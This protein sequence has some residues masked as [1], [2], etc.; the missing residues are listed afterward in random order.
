MKKKNE[1]KRTRVDVLERQTVLL[2]ATEID[3]YS[4]V[5]T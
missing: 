1:M 5:L 3:K 2:L 4:N